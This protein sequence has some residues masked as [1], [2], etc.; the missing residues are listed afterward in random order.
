MPEGFGKTLM[1]MGGILLAAGAFW[2]M[3]ANCLFLWE[4]C[5]GI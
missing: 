4:D 2:N 3:A 5:L 1:I